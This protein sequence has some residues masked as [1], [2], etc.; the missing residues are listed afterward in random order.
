MDGSLF[1]GF[2][3]ILVTRKSMGKNGKGLLRKYLRWCPVCRKD[4]PKWEWEGH[5]NGEWHRL[6]IK[7]AENFSQV[8]KR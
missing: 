5:K 4:I 3:F 6:M 8:R 2:P 7:A 1:T